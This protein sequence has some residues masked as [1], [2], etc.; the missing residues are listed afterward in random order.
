MRVQS[1]L[2]LHGN[3]DFINFWRDLS[4]K[5]HANKTFN[6]NISLLSW[7]E[8][9]Y[10]KFSTC[11]SVPEQLKRAENSDLSWLLLEYLINCW[12]KLNRNSA[13]G[14]DNIS[15]QQIIHSGSIGFEFLNALF[16]LILKHSF[17]PIKMTFVILK[18]I[19]KKASTDPNSTDNFRPIA[20]TM[21]ISKLLERIILE[22]YFQTISLNSSQHAYMG[23]HS[24]ITSLFV[25]KSTI[26]HA[27]ANKIPAFLCSLDLS[28]AFD[29]LN[30]RV[31]IDKLISHGVSPVAIS[32][33]EHWLANQMYVVKWFNKISLPFHPTLGVWRC[34]ILSPILFEIYI[35]DLLHTICTLRHG[36]MVGKNCISLVAY[37]DDI[38][39]L[40]SSLQALHNM[41]NILSKEA[42][43][44]GL[45]FNHKKTAFMKFLPQCLQHCEPYLIIDNIKILPNNSIKYLGV[46]ITVAQKLLSDMWSD[47][48]EI[49]I[50]IKYL[51]KKSHLLKKATNGL[52]DN[53]K[54]L[55]FKTF[56]YQTYGLALWQCAKEVWNSFRVAYN[57]AFRSLFN[58]Q[59][60]DHVMP[61]YMMKHINHPDAQRRFQIFSCQTSIS[62]CPNHYVKC[63]S[64]CKSNITENWYSLTH[65]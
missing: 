15:V 39:L 12:K 58:V 38:I 28:K 3:K 23:K 13:S 51:Y 59:R 49:N 21:S 55:I 52:Y 24:T 54:A 17:L 6:S 5:T 7:Q 65:F 2:K 19:L 45:K 37:A 32:L 20:L 33:I 44:I 10:T 31:L 11:P 18:P 56:F 25:V 16:R 14:V 50:K 27:T 36:I 34:G 1:L 4:G 29:S 41:I 57:N 35:D 62:L 46:H 64:L 43:E 60:Y 48:F 63:L 9:F 53:V 40:M 8:Y 26:N 47:N 61:F 30:H 22:K 42:L